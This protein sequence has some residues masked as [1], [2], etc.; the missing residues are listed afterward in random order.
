MDRECC[1]NQELLEQEAC[2]KT[3]EGEEDLLASRRQ[4][5]LEKCCECPRFLSEL[6]RWRDDGNPLAPIVDNL[7]GEYRLQKSQIQS[8]VSFLDNKSLEIRF[9][10]ELGSVLQSSVD[11]DEVLS[12][13]LTAITAGKGFGMN[14]AFLMLTDR[15]AGVLRGYLGIGPRDIGEAS[16][17][18]NEITQND[19]DLQTLAQN[20]RLNKLSSERA[21]FHD[22]L[23]CLT[24]PLENK[25]H[26]FIKALDGKTPVMVENAYYHPDVP[27]ELTR[28]LGVDTFLLMPLISRNR[29]VGMII[30][31]NFITHRPIT[32]AD[33]HS[34]ET[35]GFPVAFAIERASLYDNLQIELNRVT[36]AGRKLKEQQELIVRMENMALVGRITSSIAHSVRNP[37]MII[38]GFARSMLKNS[39]ESDP[40]RTFIESIVA[41]TRQLE[42]VL[43][44]ILNYSDS[45]YPTRDF[46]DVNQLVESALRDTADALNL[47]GYTTAYSPGIELPVVYIDFKQLSYCLRTVLQNDINCL[48]KER[49]IAISAQ[50]RDESVVLLIEDRSR[51]ISQ[52]ELDRL[53]VPF[54][55]T[56]DLGAGLALALCKTML[57]K[58]GIPFVAQADPQ[59]GIHYSITL[60]TRKE[61]H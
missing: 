48:G 13:A 29:R 7:L 14:R 45:L 32:E 59:E 18:W 60:P 39:P 19:M 27:A 23:E 52:A 4:R 46:W 25:E 55:E 12:V 6:H 9:F 58:Q 37:L 33:M 26:I 11:L 22:I 47:L 51:S 36:E 15:E 56:S 16:Q 44:E 38:G 30:A 49:F 17:V 34:L 61:E 35:F 5:N 53:L 8:L 21:K 24:V 42:G 1:W 43:D 10:H 28:L 2:P 40:K 3:G 54:S 57:E 31:D 41:E 20:F 50:A